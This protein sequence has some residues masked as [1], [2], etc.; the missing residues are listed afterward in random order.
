MKVHFNGSMVLTRLGAILDGAIFRYLRFGSYHLLARI[1]H[2]FKVVTR[3][4]TPHAV[5]PERVA[6]QVPAVF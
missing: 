6:F 3:M 2:R 1:S 4:L 5:T